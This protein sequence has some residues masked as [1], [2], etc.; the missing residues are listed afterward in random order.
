VVHLQEAAP[1]EY[2]VQTP[3]ETPPHTKV[4]DVD[5]TLAIDIMTAEEASMEKEG[6]IQGVSAYDSNN[7]LALGP[8]PTVHSH[9][10]AS[11]SKQYPRCKV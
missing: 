1:N 7:K 5:S 6:H 8:Y 4:V 3:C 9:V 11:P 10:F 2:T